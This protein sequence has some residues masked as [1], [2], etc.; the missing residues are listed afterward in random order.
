MSVWPHMN[1][2]NLNPDKYDCEWFHLTALRRVGYQSVM[3][4]MVVQ[5][6]D[7]AISTAPRVG[8]IQMPVCLRMINSLG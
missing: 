4:P 1:I 2:G 7:G 3:R 8:P 6:L 5:E